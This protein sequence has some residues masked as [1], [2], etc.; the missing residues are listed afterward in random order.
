MNA[1]LDELTLKER[2]AV[3]SEKKDYL[4]RIKNPDNPFIEEP[5]EDMVFSKEH[6][7]LTLDKIETPRNAFNLVKRSN[8]TIRRA[9]KKRAGH[10]RKTECRGNRNCLLYRP[11]HTNRIPKVQFFIADCL[12]AMMDINRQ[13]FELSCEKHILFSN[14]MDI[15]RKGKAEI[16]DLDQRLSDNY[17]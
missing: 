1:H 12:T 6:G 4:L 9:E 5:T 3:T 15:M 16:E 14:A 17:D 10:K 2:L 7:T 8:R 11:Y 13:K